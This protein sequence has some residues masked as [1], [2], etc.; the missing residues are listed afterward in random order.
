MIKIW[1]RFNKET[2]FAIPL[3]I[4]MPWCMNDFAQFATESD[5]MVVGMKALSS[6]GVEMVKTQVTMI[7]QIFDKVNGGTS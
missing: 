3:V 7:K 6:T 5:G 4:N 1:N 2:T